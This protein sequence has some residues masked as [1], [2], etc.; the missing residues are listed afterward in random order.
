MSL[1]E[2]IYLDHAATTPIH[3]LVIEEMTVEMTKTFGNP[4]SV[5]SFGREAHT[6]LEESRQIISNSLNVSPREI[7][8]NSGGTEGDN[9]AIIE[10]AF[11]KKES[12][13][14]IIT[15]VFEHPAVLKTMAYLEEQ[16]FEVTY[17]RVDS[18][19]QI[20]LEDFKQALRD[21]TILVSMMYG[22][23]EV[24]T[25]LPIKEIGEILKDHPA[26]FHTDAVQAYGLE[27][28]DPKEF[29]IDLF[30]ISAHKINGPKGV[31]FLYKSDAVQLLPLLHGGEQESKRRA[32]TEN[33][34][35]IAGL[36]QAV[37]LLTTEEKILRKEKY[38]SFQKIVLERLETA[39]IEYHVN[40]GLENRLAHILNLW[41]PGV[42]SE[43]LLMNLDLQ[44]IAVST[45]SACSAGTVKPSRVLE[46]IYGEGHP[47]AEESVRISFGLNNTVEQIERFAE[48]LIQIIDRIRR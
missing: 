39:A 30:S 20:S 21:E 29:G 33:L 34:A 7:I 9:T 28:V 38:Q 5:H 12:G 45:G 35:G 41:I 44:G 16:G 32:G 1:L 6:K 26:V 47:A 11:L 40:G 24:G 31:G 2:R 13:Q 36:A 23:N 25:L 19:G 17:L 42:S 15:S 4:S 18:K 46:T 22:N 8:F 27:V 10:T 43:L 37:K 3:P 48:V 14:H